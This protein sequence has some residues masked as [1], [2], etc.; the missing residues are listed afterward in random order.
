MKNEKLNYSRML[1]LCKMFVRENNNLQI[2]LNDLYEDY[3]QVA[4][5]LR[6][7]VYCQNKLMEV[8]LKNF[9][10]ENIEFDCQPSFYHFIKYK[11]CK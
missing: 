2:L 7:L 8:L 1:A 9:G 6:Y 11:K 3:N 10:I 4:E 5:S